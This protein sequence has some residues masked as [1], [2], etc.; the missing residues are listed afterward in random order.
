MNTPLLHTT[1]ARDNQ[2]LAGLPQ[3]EWERWLPYLEPV[4]LA[5]GQVLSESGRAPAYVYFPTTAIVSL[6]YMTCLDRA[7]SEVAWAGGR[8]LGAR[9][10]I[11]LGG[12]PTLDATR[13][14]RHAGAAHRVAAG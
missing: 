9:R 2:L 12:P 13:S 7:R 14:R 1:D 5:L 3:A 4:H 11:G 10:R 8:G 6:L